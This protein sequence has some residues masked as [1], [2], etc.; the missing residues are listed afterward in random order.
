MCGVL[1]NLLSISS[2]AC[3]PFFDGAYLGR[4]SK[5]TFL[6]MPEGDF[7]SEL[8]NLMQ[9][10]GMTEYL[11]PTEHIGTDQADI[12]DFKEALEFYNEP[13]RDKAL[14]NYLQ[15]RYQIEDYR[16]RIPIKQVWYGDHFRRDETD[17]PEENLYLELDYEWALGVPEEFALY[18]QGA[19]VYFSND[20]EGAIRNWKELLELPEEERKFKSTWAA[21]MIGKAYLNIYNQ[22]DAVEFFEKT[23][24]LAEQGF[25]DSL[26]LRRESIGWQALAELEQGDFVSSVLYYAMVLDLESLR[27][28]MDKIYSGEND[29]FNQIV[30]DDVSRDIVIAWTAANASL[31]NDYYFDSKGIEA[32]R[33][34][35]FGK[36]IDGIKKDKKFFN[37]D[38]MAWLFYNRGE[39]ERAKKWLQY[40]QNDSLLAKWIDAKITLR[41]GDI[42]LALK[43]LQDLLPYFEKTQD[44]LSFCEQNWVDSCKYFGSEFVKKEIH[45]EI[46]VLKLR[47]EEYVQALDNLVYGRFWEDVAYLAENVLTV[48]E[49]KRY[50]NDR[51]PQYTWPELEYAKAASL[52][53]KTTYYDGLVYL[54]ARRL[55]RMGN[56][57]KAIKYMPD[58]FEVTWHRR[59]PSGEGYLIHSYERE[60]INVKDLTRKLYKYLTQAINQSLSN[61]DR[62]NNYY[63]AALIMRN[64]GMEIVGTELDPDWFV[65]DGQFMHG[66]PLVHRFGDY[67]KDILEQY[68]GWGDWAKKYVDEMK[69]DQKQKKKAVKEGKDFYL[70]SVNE[71]KRALESM[72]EPRR[73]FHYRFKAADL[74]WKAAELL[75][76][77]DKLKAEALWEG[78]LY[79]RDRDNQAADK[80]YKELVKTCKNTVLGVE[81]ARIHWFPKQEWYERVKEK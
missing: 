10:Y 21:F 30:K 17:Q 6:A 25:K 8:L 28:V 46:G 24:Q 78:G 18:L 22:V 36:L 62:A 14:D 50:L 64:Y 73:R 76:E 41:E 70:A 33:Y 7:R 5:E 16:N 4:T 27:R 38:R 66:G 13:L 79:L 61:R 39:I 60:K 74:M 51:G 42:N 9:Y 26:N 56:W 80:F 43:K 54:L 53:E 45:S 81:A 72:P 69:E 67:N 52:K 37:A 57:D 58:L 75:P 44:S 40:A 29:V 23:R 3:G 71:K 15:I 19:L 11:E 77:N 12:A 48:D 32:K 31:W 47:K 55:G 35:K 68:D 34:E 20:F 1:F 59:K 63:E 2:Y 49:L 65:D